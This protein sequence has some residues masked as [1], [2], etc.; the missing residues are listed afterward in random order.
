M[1]DPIR[2]AEAEYQRAMRDVA[3]AQRDAHV[4]ERTSETAPEHTSFSGG[5]ENNGRVSA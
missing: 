2:E 1:S 3:Q 4:P 5:E